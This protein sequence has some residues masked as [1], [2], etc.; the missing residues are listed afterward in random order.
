P[1]W[2]IKMFG[3]DLLS[4]NPTAL[5]I[6][7]VAGGAEFTY[8]K[9]GFDITAAAWF[10]GLSWDGGVSFK[11]KS[12]D[13]NSWEVVTNDMQA[14]LLTVDFIWSTEI[15]DWFAVTYG[16]GL[17]LGIPWGD[18]IRTEATQASNGL[19][20][21]AGKEDPDPWCNDDEEYFETYKVPT[22]IIPWVNLLLGMR[23][24][25]HRHVALYAD[26]GF[27]LGFQSGVRAAYVF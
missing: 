26:M 24:K 3:V 16:A 19:S 23:F 5:L 15:T 27:G 10:I 13:G 4:K 25:P 14:L 22:G 11:G 12:E 9:D 7:N 1:D 2:F 21:C 20:R 17:G 18:I 8:R 6:N